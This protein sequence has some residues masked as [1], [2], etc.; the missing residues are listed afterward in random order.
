MKKRTMVS[1][2]AGCV[3]AIGTV[4]AMD[5][6]GPLG[7]G[8]GGIDIDGGTNVGITN[9]PGGCCGSVTVTGIPTNICVSC[10]VTGRVEWI[11][12]GAGCE[13]LFV[14]VYSVPDPPSPLF[15]YTE[16]VSIST[17]CSMDTNT[18][19][20]ISNIICGTNGVTNICV[21][22]LQPGKGTLVWEMLCGGIPCMQAT[23]RLDVVGVASVTTD[24]PIVSVGT[25]VV[26]TVTTIPPGYFHMV[27][28]TASGNAAPASSQRGGETFTAHWDTA[29]I[30]VVTAA[31]ACCAT[32]DL[33]T[34]PYSYAVAT[35]TVVK[36]DYNIDHVCTTGVH[37]AHV[38]PVT[39]TPSSA[40]VPI[41][42]TLERVTTGG[43]GAAVFTNTG[44]STMTIYGSTNVTV[45]GT[46]V[47]DVVSNM[48]MRAQL[49]S[50]T[51]LCARRFTVV[52]TPWLTLTNVATGNSVVDLTQTNEPQSVTNT[53]FLGEG[54]NGTAV[55]TA[56][57]DWMPSGVTNTRFRYE[58]RLTNGAPTTQWLPSSAGDFTTNPVTLTWTN[59]QDSNGMTNRM[60]MVRTWFDCEGTGVYDDT[61]PHR[62]LYVSVIKVD[63]AMDG[64]RDGDIDFDGTND[65]HCLFWVND[66]HDCLHFEE[67]EWHED[68][69]LD[70]ADGADTP[71]C[72]D[73]R[74]GAKGYI[75][76]NPPSASENHCRRDL[77]DFTR[78]HI[79][80]DDTAANMSGIT[81][82]MKFENVSSG[83]PSANIF[84]AI[85]EGLD[86]LENGSIA[87]QQ[88]QKTRLITVGTSEVQLPNQYIKTG[89]QRSPFILEGKTA[90][91]GDL[92]IIV[93]KGNAEVCRKTV[94]LELRPIGKFYQVFQV[95]TVGQNST[96]VSSGY[97]PDFTS[98]DDYL[99][100]VHGFNV[101]AVDKTYW[102]GTVFK[103]LW[104]QGY[105]GHVGFFSWPCVMFSAFNLQCYD[106]SE[107]NAWRCGAALS[108]RIN[109]LNSGVH[110]GK[111]RLLAHS[112][113]N[114]VAGEALRLASG[115]VVHTYIATQ[116]AVPADCYQS[117]V[118]EY[119]NNYSTPNVFLSFPPTANTYLTGVSSKAGQL[120]SYYNTV[121]YAL[122][123]VWVGSWEWNNSARPDLSY[124]YAGPRDTYDTSAQ[125]TPS[126]FYY[127]VVPYVPPAP[128][129]MVFAN[130]TF[131]IFSYAAEAR[132]SA[133]GVQSA[134]DD[135]STFNLRGAPLNYDQAHYSH[136]RQFRSNIVDEWEYWNTV[137]QDCG[138]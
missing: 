132:G 111:V 87:D 123:S 72:D 56:A 134:M 59:T 84:E 24:T 64:N 83:S 48:A 61:E 95:A 34:S 13:T 5:L 6:N 100:F 85:N 42:L 30:Y 121:D 109:Q 88:I 8:G 77:E 11:T 28:W 2:L 18:V 101:N 73:D 99:L 78:L 68:D 122:H 9:P 124:W 90:G 75:G 45:M 92:T 125:S 67:G 16:K 38:V 136:S 113:G 137:K 27:E 51:A 54:T 53:L 138:F 71:N 103:R 108:D 47:S 10:C 37:S 43:S 40:G 105:K 39:V 98:S 74:I 7:P 55:M 70:W 112:Q 15:P 57:F 36:V 79:R 63:F 81:Y 130:D 33:G 117:G 60:F 119:Y 50:G 86:Y 58:V 80:V 26:F 25:D 66:D 3:V 29:G 46:E 35:V 133:L 22:G 116:A 129:D 94:T 76:G 52:D 115:Q 21:R 126:R 41:T 12:E 65:N 69:S 127:D 17:N 120:F 89:S 23:Q 102:P 131:E 82:W 31:C 106:D 97:N 114:V 128:R 20:L 4:V 93:K 118:S 110:S 44:L 14:K 19:F 32:C 91:K 96:D 104:L 49:A 1:L 135:F 107:Y 62:M